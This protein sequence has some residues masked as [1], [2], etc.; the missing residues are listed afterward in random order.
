[1]A[2][3]TE[4]LTIRILGD[5]SH[6]QNALDGVT[7]RLSDL[8]SRLSQIGNIE[9]QI[10]R[11]VGRFSRLTRPLEEVSRLLDRIANQARLLGRIPINLNVA[12][13]INSLNVLSRMID[14]I[15]VK[16]R[17]LSIGGIG[18]GGFPLPSPGRVPRFA[19]GGLVSGPGGIDQIPALLTAGEFVI[20][21]PVVQQLGATFLSALN[22]NL[23]GVLPRGVPVTT[24]SAGPAPVNNFGGISINVMQAADVNTIVRDLRFQGIRLRNRRG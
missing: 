13:A 19:D 5:S 16:A 6:L 3:F 24:P 12:P 8:Q 15:A 10:G 1:M 17:L 2:N 9:Q 20:R 14:Q 4:S 11:T 22:Q 21:Q 23:R 7:R 18:G